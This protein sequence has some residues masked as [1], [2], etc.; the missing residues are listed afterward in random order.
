VTEYSWW[1]NI[2]RK[3]S[4][5][6][7]SE[8]KNTVMFSTFTVCVWLSSNKVWLWVWL[9]RLR[10]RLWTST[11]IRYN[12]DIRQTNHEL[13]GCFLYIYQEFRRK[14]KHLPVKILKEDRPSAKRNNCL[15]A[16]CDIKLPFFQALLM[17]FLISW[18]RFVTISVK[19]V[20]CN[21]VS[22]A[23]HLHYKRL[24]LSKKKKKRR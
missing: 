19:R 23:I 16:F 6:E 15:Y 24:V 5:R 17:I 10:G 21:R 11:G 22:V 12:H 13:N 4:N 18:Y 8:I 2:R 3:F 14:R 7:Y 1:F 20:Y 9:F